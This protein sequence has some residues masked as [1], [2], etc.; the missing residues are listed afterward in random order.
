MKEQY[1]HSGSNNLDKFQSFS[2]VDP[3]VQ[4]KNNELEE[5][6]GKIIGLENAAIKT[7][8]QI[9]FENSKRQK[10]HSSRAKESKN[11]IKFKSLKIK[12]HSS[13]S[14]YSQDNKSSSKE[15]KKIAAETEKMALMILRYYLFDMDKAEDICSANKSVKF[16]CLSQDGSHT[17]HNSCYFY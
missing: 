16:L 2:N 15:V 3:S 17:Q 4:Q 7:L 12:N 11:Q 1:R 8:K 9:A 5:K 14:M 6:I 10:P 13:R